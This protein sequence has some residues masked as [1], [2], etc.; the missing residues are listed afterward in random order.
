MS[1][2]DLQQQVEEIGSMDLEALRTLWGQRYGAP[3]SLRSVPIMR[4][5]LAWRIQADAMGG[6]DA[7]MHKELA[8]TGPVEVE[9]RHF[10]VGALLTRTW[11]GRPVEVLVE[12]EGFR[13]DGRLFPSLSAAATAIAGSKWNGPRFFGLRDQP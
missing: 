5:M 4:M 10:G 1:C 13:W 6:L 11:K 12:E 2:V 3:P 8:R 9:G 7:R